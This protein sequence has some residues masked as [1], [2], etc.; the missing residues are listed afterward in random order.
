[1]TDVGIMPDNS[2]SNRPRKIQPR[3]TNVLRELLASPEEGKGAVL[4]RLSSPKY[5]VL[6]GPTLPPGACPP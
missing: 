4:S 6:Q 1:M 2:D 3:E 5:C